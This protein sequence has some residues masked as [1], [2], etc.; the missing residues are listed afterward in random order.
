MNGT[1]LFNTE[2]VLALCG[3]L[4]VFL[5]YAGIFF[6]EKKTEKTDLDRVSELLDADNLA[7]KKSGFI[8]TA[9]SYGL[10]VALGQANLNVTKEV[11]IRDG[12]IIM[13]VLA[14]AGWITS[15]NIVVMAVLAGIAWF[16]YL[17]WLF[18][19][20]DKVSLEYEE[21]LADV[22]DRMASGASLDNSLIGMIRHT[23]SLAPS[24]VRPD[25][26]LIHKNLVQGATF[27]E[28][29]AEVRRKRHS[30]SLNLLL[31]TLAMWDRKGTSIPLVKVLQPLTETIRARQRARQR[32]NADLQTQKSTL[33]IITASPFVFMVAMRLF[34]PD[35]REA[36]QTPE[37]TFFLVLS[38]ATACVGYIVGNKI[39]N[40]AAKVL[41]ISEN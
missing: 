7:Y 5:V 39:L 13:A 27:A 36:Y 40:S 6:R 38:I 20:R 31:D 23:V 8:K 12:C 25:F 28:A 4:G 41:E 18:D 17:L 14:A 22:A 32:V 33:Y 1:P 37:G 3:A 35:S 29:T 11:F 15:H 10:E 24:I 34:F 26:E 9:R 21:A 30:S 16:A 2:I 19:R